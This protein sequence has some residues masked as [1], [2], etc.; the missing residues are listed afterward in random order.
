M[1]VAAF[2]SGHSPEET[3]SES[4]CADY[5]CSESHGVSPVTESELRPRSDLI[6]V[7]HEPL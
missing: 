5:E 3:D 6:G 1:H 2:T 7:D 4:E